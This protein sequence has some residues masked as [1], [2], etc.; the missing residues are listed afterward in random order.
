MTSTPLLDKARQGRLA[1]LA[2]RATRH[3]QGDNVVS[4]FER[5]FDDRAAARA[6]V[7][8]FRSQRGRT[9]SARPTAVLQRVA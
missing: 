2:A 7:V 4:I 3:A 6:A 5:A 9:A 1:A 8:T